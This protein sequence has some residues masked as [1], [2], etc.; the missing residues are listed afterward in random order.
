M[1]PKILIVD[2]EQDIRDVLVLTLADLGY[3]VLAA[4]DGKQGLQL[5][6]EASPPIV[7]TDIK[8]PGMD[9]IELLRKLKAENPETEVLMI[10]GHGDLDLAILSLKHEATDFITKPINIDVL[11]IALRRAQERILTRQKLKEYTEHLE[12][13]VREK[14]ELQSRLSSLGLMIGSISH[15]IKGLLTGLDGGIYLVES[16][17]SHDD[18]QKTKDGW[19]AVKLTI[20]RIRRLMHD[21]MYYSKERELKIERVKPAEFAHQLTQSFE[22]KVRGQCIDFEC[23][24][25]PA[26][27]EFEADASYLQAAMANILENAV[28]ACRKDECKP[29]HCITFRVRREKGEIAFEIVDDGTGMDSDTRAKLFDLFFSSKGAEGTGLGLFVSQKIVEQHGGRIDVK[30][31]PGHGSLFRVLIPEKAAARGEPQAVPI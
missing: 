6:H 29:Q 16:G 21:I 28:D 26:V 13:L 27:A 18:P 3:D 14:T 5:F 4:E 8:M 25:D 10:T 22:A 20:E 23:E 1:K 12:Q 2:D 15:G 11:E 30:S 24:V 17:F 9:G 7:V 31:T 19:E